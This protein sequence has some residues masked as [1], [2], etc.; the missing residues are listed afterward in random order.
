LFDLLAE[1]KAAKAKVARAKKV[2]AAEKKQKVKRDKEYL[3]DIASVSGGTDTSSN[4]LLP[5][6]TSRATQTG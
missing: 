2:A 5:L 3:A 6:S 4:P 1:E